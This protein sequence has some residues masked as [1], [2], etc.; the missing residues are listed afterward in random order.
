MIIRPA[1]SRATLGWSAI[2]KHLTTRSSPWFSVFAEP[3]KLRQGGL[4]HDMLLVLQVDVAKK[5]EICG[6]KNHHLQIWPSWWWWWWWW[7]WCLDDDDFFR[8]SPGFRFP[9]RSSSKK[10]TSNL[11]VGKIKQSTYNWNSST[12][13]WVGPREKKTIQPLESPDCFFRK[14]HPHPTPLGKKNRKDVPLKP[15]A[16]AMSCWL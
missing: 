12:Y 10:K 16:N 1:I 6:L 7:W 15:W 11:V 5:R 2:K 14:T 9:L 13:N 8:V 3:W 4:D